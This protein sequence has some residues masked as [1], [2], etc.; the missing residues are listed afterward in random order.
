MQFESF[1]NHE[2]L[3]ITDR[4]RRSCDFLVIVYSAKLRSTNQ[5][6]VTVS[7]VYISSDPFVFTSETFELLDPTSEILERLRLNLGHLLN[8]SGQLRKSSGVFGCFM[9]AFGS[10]S[11]SKRKVIGTPG[12]YNL[13]LIVLLSSNQNPVILLS[14]P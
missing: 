14:V 4:T 8:S 13:G 10:L 11:T 9:V 12:E 1:Q 6:A 7:F 2:Y 5:N 3:L